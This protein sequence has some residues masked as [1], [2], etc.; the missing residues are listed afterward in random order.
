MFFTHDPQAGFYYY[1]E[2]EPTATTYKQ[3]LVESSP[4]LIGVDVETISLKERIAI[5]VGISIKPNTSF[6]FVLFPEPSPATPWHLLKDPTITKVFHNALFDLSA[7][8]EYEIDNT[9]VKD[10]AVM[11]RLL[12]HKFNKLID[13]CH[14]CQMEVH[15]AGEYI[16]KGGTTLDVEQAVMAKKC[17][18]DS[19]ATLK[20]YYEFWEDI[21]HNYLD[22]EMQTIPIMIEMS[23]RGLLIDQERRQQ[24]EE[25]LQEQTDYYQSI[26]A[27]V[28][29][30]PGSPQQVAYTLA[31]RKAY[32]SFTKL[33]F[34]KGCGKRSLSTAV[35]VLEKMD[36]PLASIVLQYRK[37]SKLLS[38]YIKPWAHDD[39][40][41]TRFHLDAI[42]GRPSSTD[43]NMQNIPGKFRKDGTEYTHNCRGVLL[44]DNHIWTDID[45]EQLEPRVLAYLS[46]DREMQ[47]IFSLPKLNPDGTRNENADIHLQVA[48]FM[49]IT[50]RLGKLINLAM[51]Y[52]ATDETL[53]EQCGIRSKVRVGQ[54]RDMWGKKF[55]QAMDWIDSRQEDAL[56]TGRARTIFGRNI[57]LPTLDEENV[58]GIKRKAIDYPCQGSAAEILKRG[59]ILCK[60][61]PMAL[62]VHD[63]LLIDSFVPDYRFKPL[64]YIA[65]FTTP[66]E[67]KYLERWE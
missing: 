49:G 25:E 35:E 54:L 45:W 29:F 9:N 22:V 65:P 51:T 5:G 36:D 33:P 2:E 16:P 1:G 63:E 60:D 11:S 47:Y 32:S 59:L 31:S 28:G 61:L 17:M 62:Q 39:R 48:M 19:G 57:R 30:N 58:D 64:E 8:R 10:T 34:T 67:V 4:K 66:I 42:T 44:P 15:E 14:I 38:T 46:G 20:L 56:R 50:R 18:Q 12:C 23:N 27:E 52:G 6:Y 37:H 13:L 43:R 7:L 53:M 40:A 26:C 3:L 55:P 21:D 24:I 41:Y